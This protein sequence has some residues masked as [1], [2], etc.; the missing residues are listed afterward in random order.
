MKVVEIGKKTNVCLVW[1]GVNKAKEGMFCEYFRVLVMTMRL[2]MS[3]EQLIC[4]I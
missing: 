3:F 4:P 1:E 2:I